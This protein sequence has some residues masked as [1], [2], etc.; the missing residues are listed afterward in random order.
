M[1]PDPDWKI[2]NQPRVRARTSGD[3][4]DKGNNDDQGG[5]IIVWMIKKFSR[6]KTEKSAPKKRDSKKKPAQPKESDDGTGRSRRAP[7][8]RTVLQDC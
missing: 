5:D 3:N 7:L 2:E 4:K 1:L 6:E 8:K